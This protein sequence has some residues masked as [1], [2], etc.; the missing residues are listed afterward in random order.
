MW[1]NL[2]DPELLR[3]IAIEEE[4]ERQL[5]LETAMSNVKVRVPSIDLE[6][7]LTELEGE[8]LAYA[9][10]SPRVTY[11][12]EK[13]VVQGTVAK[14]TSTEQSFSVPVVICKKKINM[15]DRLRGDGVVAPLPPSRADPSVSGQMKIAIDV[16]LTLK[17][18]RETD[19]VVVVGSSVTEGFSGES[20]RLLAGSVARVDLYD[21]GEPEERE[22]RIQGTLFSYHRERWPPGKRIEADV[23]F[24]DAFDVEKKRAILFPVTARVYSIKDARY[25]EAPAYEEPIARLYPDA[26]PYVQLSNTTEWRWTNTDRRFQNYAARLGSCA[27]CRE[28]DYRAGKEFTPFQYDVWVSMHAYSVAKCTIATHV[29][30]PLQT[31]ISTLIWRT[32][33]RPL[34]LRPYDGKSVIT[35]VDRHAPP[36][37]VKETTGFEWNGRIF[38]YASADDKE[39]GDD[40]RPPAS[41]F[42]QN[43]LLPRTAVALQN[44]PGRYSVPGAPTAAFWAILVVDSYVYAMAYLYGDP[45][46]G[47]RERSV[48]TSQSVDY[49]YGPIVSKNPIGQW[50]LY[51]FEQLVATGKTPAALSMR[52]LLTR[53][54]K[55]YKTMT[56]GEKGCEKM[57]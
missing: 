41:R 14:D 35:L 47:R 27:A 17:D 4:R 51:R 20:Y 29:R 1:I 23:V 5:Q 13:G 45:A 46:E 3:L 44:L 30:P 54:T 2:Q 32:T 34:V 31:N 15:D 16:A 6:G 12:E 21:P 38:V 25:A 55:D 8:D 40:D 10:F 33:V 42:P 18:L 56:G 24:V 28:V 57:M 9:L 11:T 22:E 19:N 7:G 43:M 50:F 49:V 36:V 53:R 48:G 39:V 37:V 26:K 52:V